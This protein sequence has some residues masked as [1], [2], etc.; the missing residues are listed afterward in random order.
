MRIERLKRENLEPYSR[1]QLPPEGDLAIGLFSIEGSNSTGKTNLVEAILWALWSPRAIHGLKQEQLV[2]RGSNS[3]RVQLNFSVSGAGYQ[4]NR[5]YRIGS[6]PD[7]ALLR[8]HDGVYVPVAKGAT[9]VTALEEILGLEYG[10]VLDTVFIRQGEVDSLSI[11]MPSV[12]RDFILDLF[13][14]DILDRIAEKLKEKTGALDEEI[15]VLEKEMAV[16]PEK[17]RSRDRL[18]KEICEITSD[19]SKLVDSIKKLMLELERIPKVSILTKIEETQTELQI[20]VRDMEDIQEE[21]KSSTKRRME[22]DSEI[23]RLP[24][25]YPQRGIEYRRPTDRGPK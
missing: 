11:A 6:S 12:L 16:K 14:L 19:I 17:E 8:A 5:S 15:S 10:E 2:K 13:R 22:I 9:E 20:L 4:V 3:C 21:I 25:L 23:E 7:L 18:G 1:V 24:K